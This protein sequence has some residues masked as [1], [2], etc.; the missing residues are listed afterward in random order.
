MKIREKKLI[1]KLSFSAIAILV[2]STTWAQQIV[3]GKVTDL[4]GS[5]IPGV[6]IAVKGTL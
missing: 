4:D 3:T 5:P 1:R 6:N 2:V